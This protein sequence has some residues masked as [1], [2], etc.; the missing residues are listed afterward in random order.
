[1][2]TYA[3]IEPTA[4]NM[5]MTCWLLVLATTTENSLPDTSWLEEELRNS[6]NASRGGLLQELDMVQRNT[7]ARKLNTSSWAPDDDL[8]WCQR[9]LLLTKCRVWQAQCQLIKSHARA[10]TV[11][12]EQGILF[13]LTP[14]LALRH[15]S[16]QRITW[17]LYVHLR[18]VWMPRLLTSAQLFSSASCCINLSF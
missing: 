3:A 12:V 14:P 11:R 5:C 7:L 17:R 9:G 16:P 1:M 13:F 10:V 8:C 18:P 2:L 6:Q 4:I 15:G